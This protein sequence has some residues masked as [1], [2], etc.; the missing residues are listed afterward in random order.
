M[1]FKRGAFESLEKILRL[2]WLWQCRSGTEREGRLEVHGQ[3]AFM[4]DAEGEERVERKEKKKTVTE[5]LKNW[6]KEV[7]G[8]ELA[9]S[10]KAN[11]ET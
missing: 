10:S 11:Q 4:R 6:A 8:R 9:E 7:K 5:I 3:E 1:S 2:T